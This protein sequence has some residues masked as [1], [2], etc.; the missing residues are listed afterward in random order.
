MFYD[1]HIHSALSPCA[2]DDMTPNNIVNMSLIK[3][4]ELI[5]VC[6]HNA[7]DQQAALA[8]VA[9]K[10][11]LNYLYGIEVQSS[12]EVHLLAFFQKWEDIS[13]FGRWISNYLLPIE[14]DPA[15]FGRQLIMNELDE[16]IGEKKTLL[17]QSVSLS[18]DE[19]CKRIHQYHGLVV[20]A[21]AMDRTNSIMTQLGFIPQN[22]PFDGIEIKN[23]E[24]KK[25]LLMI[26]PWLDSDLLWLIS[27]DAHQLTDISEAEHEI[28]IEELWKRWRNYL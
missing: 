12:E 4:L 22:L 5:A 14:N 20:L 10:N 15:F 17:I 24:Q 18:I 23:N 6:D 16:I 7:I 26:H 2:N 25:Q 9:K 13:Q 27:S 28:K 8:C 19:L 3:G 21:H 1:L 11:G